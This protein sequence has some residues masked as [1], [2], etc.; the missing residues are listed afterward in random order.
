MKNYNK[1]DILMIVNALLDYSNTAIIKNNFIKNFK[2][3]TVNNRLYGHYNI[4]GTQSWRLSSN[5]PNLLNLPSTGSIYAKPVKRCFK[6][7]DDHIFCMIDFSALEDRVIANLSKDKNKCSIF[8][9]N[10][11]GHCLNSYFYFKDEV[12]KELPRGENEELADYIKRYKTETEHNKKLKSIRQKS[13]EITFGLSY[14]AYPKKIAKALKS[15]IEYATNI[16]NS[17]HTNLYNGISRYREQVEKVA[18]TTGRVHLGLGAY[19]YVDN[20]YKSIRSVFNCCSQFWAILSLITI[21][22]I[23]SL[24]KE[25]G[26]END[27]EIVSSI[28]DSIYFH[29]RND[30]TVIKWLN[31]NLIPIMTK[32]YLKDI[33]VHNEAEMEIG[34]NWADTVI[35]RN[36]ASLEEII[37]AVEQAKMLVDK[38]SEPVYS[39]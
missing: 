27:I 17:Y 16:F 38:S 8:N 9:D 32:D 11:D 10:L 24:V 30:I 19:I 14:G 28:Y 21:E 2:L 7:Y 34:F 23:M 6:A 29:V 31:D 13:K 15:S 26:L 35:V 37:E 18:K 3:A 25:Q 39:A 20:I 1:K 12:E 5:R 4:T 22:K 33:I 36:G